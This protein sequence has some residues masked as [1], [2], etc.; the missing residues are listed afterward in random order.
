M[1]DEDLLR[2]ILQHEARDVEPR[3]SFAD[4][5]RRVRHR[6]ER[7]A[8]L[9]A[10]AASVLVVVL[11]VVLGGREPDTGVVA[12][13]PERTT[14]TPTSEPPSTTTSPAP[15][16]EI[17]QGVWPFTTDAQA[18]AFAASD[19]GLAF[20]D[21]E[22]TARAFLETYLGMSDPEVGAFSR[23]DGRSG[24]LVARP[25]PGGPETVLFL[26]LVGERD[27]W[28]VSGAATDSIRLA[29]PSPLAT[30][31]SPLEV[32]GESCCAFEGT[33]VVQLRE[34][35][36]ERP[37]QYRAQEALIGGAMGEHEP[38]SGQLT[39]SQ[40]SRPAGAVVAFTTSPEDGG[41]E[42]ATVVRVSFAADG[43]GSAEGDTTFPRGPA[44]E[45]GGVVAVFEE[46]GVETVGLS[47]DVVDAGGRRVRTLA[48]ADGFEGGFLDV[49]LT[50]DRRTVLYAVS[51]SACTSE[52]RAV[53]SDGATDVA[54][55]PGQLATATRLAPHPDG[56]RLALATD[57]DCDGR[58]EIVVRAG[59][60]T[61]RRWAD[62]GSDDLSGMVRS[63]A[64]V[65]D[66]TLALSIQYEDGVAT[67]LH[68]LADDHLRVGDGPN[69][70]ALDGAAYDLA[71]TTGAD[72][73]FGAVRLCCDDPT[74]TRAATVLRVDRDGVPVD[75]RSVEIGDVIVALQWFG[76]GPT[77]VT[78]DGVLRRTSGG[79]TVDMA[80]NVRDV[81]AA[82]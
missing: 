41:V 4:V 68:D 59:D 43:E 18:D 22:E 23:A 79:E 74:S 38:I 58:S 8:L 51:T 60:G 82:A 6:R 16:E 29:W 70:S 61:E 35:G 62:A 30:V 72:G 28:T 37:D 66:T 31:R 44:L 71:T 53:S 9:G 75:D 55:D 3:G 45:P 25:R 34:D 48:A 73:S 77:W 20:T 81:A 39:F 52:V 63:I 15:S 1:N 49:A 69:V 27:L 50:P 42:R 7:L 67:Q 40:P 32:R 5:R 46:P 11:V 26:R 57:D 19:V 80:R 36:Q 78:G 12:D 65:D 47:L 13:S 76:D 14:T 2:R 64:W 10:V 33:V 24:E 21:P 54:I 56:Q 17:G